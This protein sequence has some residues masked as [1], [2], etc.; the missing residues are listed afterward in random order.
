MATK[1]FAVRSASGGGEEEVA[2]DE[3]VQTESSISED[4]INTLVK[5]SLALERYFKRPQEIEWAIDGE[6][7][8]LDSSIPPFGH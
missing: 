8:L 4:T 5:W 7:E 6:W 1:R 3:D 2:L